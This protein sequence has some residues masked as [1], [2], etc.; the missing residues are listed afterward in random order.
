MNA[1]L[2]KLRDKCTDKQ[3]KFTELFKNG[4]EPGE[5][6]QNAGFKAKRKRIAQ[7]AASRLLTTNTNVRAYLIALRAEDERKTNITR[8]FQLKR[9]N[10]LYEMAV[11][12][13]N[14]SAGTSA[15]REQNEMLGYHREKGLNPEREASKRAAMSKEERKL[16]EVKAKIRT[17]DESREQI[18]LSPAG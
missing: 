12:Q 9:L 4:Q 1:K 7:Q 10:N 16:A 15:I 5:A 3:A 14:V 17:A 2:Q 8:V 11:E 6:Y 18:K 13:G